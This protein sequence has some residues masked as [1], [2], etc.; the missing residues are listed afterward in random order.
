MFKITENRKT[1]LKKVPTRRGAAIWSTFEQRIRRK[2][3]ESARY[4][5]YSLKRVSIRYP[6]I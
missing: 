4:D 1:E 3:Y 5:W 2:G 6:R